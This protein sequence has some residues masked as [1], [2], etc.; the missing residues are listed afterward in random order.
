MADVY[1]YS[2]L[3]LREARGGLEDDLEEFLGTTGE[4]TGGGGGERGWNIDLEISDA[5]LPRQIEKIKDFLQEW[6]VPPDTYF[7]VWSEQNS[8]EKKMRYDVYAT[9]EVVEWIDTT[10]VYLAERLDASPSEWQSVRNTIE[11]K[12]ASLEVR[13]KNRA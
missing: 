4:V 9:Q 10:L 1:I 6:G 5:A 11:E 2:S 12:L 7:D 8:E 3:P 13:P